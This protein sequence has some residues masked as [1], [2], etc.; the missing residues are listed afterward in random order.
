[1]WLLIVGVMWGVSMMFFSRSTTYATAFPF[2]F[3]VGFMSAV[4]MSL[5]MTLAQTYSSNAMRGRIMSIGMMSF[6]AMPLSALPFGT[7]AEYIGTPNALTISG[8]MLTV[9]T[10]VFAILTP[11]FR[12]IE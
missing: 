10:L 1:M 4:F 6:G 3:L 12:K 2:L 5:N 8:V 9:L 11:R 7:I